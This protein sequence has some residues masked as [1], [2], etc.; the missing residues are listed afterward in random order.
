MPRDWLA[1]KCRF[2]QLPQCNGRADTAVGE[3]MEKKLRLVIF[4]I[5]E[6]LKNRQSR[7]EEIATEFGLHE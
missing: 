2:P 7:L 6:R 1:S 5:R 4:W 3:D